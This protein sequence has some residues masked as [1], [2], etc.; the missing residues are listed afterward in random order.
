MSNFIHVYSSNDAVNDRVLIDLCQLFPS[1]V[2]EAGIKIPFYCSRSVYEKYI[3]LTP[4]A[5][6]A[7]NDEKGRAWDVIYMS[8][9]A[10][11]RAFQTYNPCYFQFYCVVDRIKPKLC[12]CKAV[13]DGAAFTLMEVDED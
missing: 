12:K 7:L 10:L 11:K 4:K 6:Q 1:E 9:P 3:A 8:R 5:K 13:Y 2:F